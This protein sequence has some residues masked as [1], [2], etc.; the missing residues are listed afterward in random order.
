MT[1][2]LSHGGT[3]MY[4]STAAAQRLLVGTAG[5]VVILERPAGHEWRVVGRALAERHISA[6]ITPAPGLVVAGVFHDSVYVSH[7]DGETWE[8]RGDGLEPTNVYSLAAVERTGH[9]RL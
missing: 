7:D 5:G 6:L 4:V 2:A 3:T 8:R 9:L 1:I